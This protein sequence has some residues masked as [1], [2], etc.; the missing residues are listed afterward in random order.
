MPLVKIVARGDTTVV[1]AYLNPVLR[2]YTEKLLESLPNCDL[3]IV[4][5]AGGLVGS[6]KFTGKDS[7]LPDRPLA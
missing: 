7:L 5:S 2:R 4:T 1:D 3:R 6:R